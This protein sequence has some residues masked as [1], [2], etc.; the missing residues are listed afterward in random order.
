M[1]EG[2]VHARL[3]QSLKALT[4]FG[5]EGCPGNAGKVNK[6]ESQTV[7]D[8]DSLF[9]IVLKMVK[10]KLTPC[11]GQLKYGLSFSPSRRY[12]YTNVW[13]RPCKVLPNPRLTFC[14]CLDV[15]S[16]HHFADVVISFCPDVVAVFS[17]VI[18]IGIPVLGLGANLS[19]FLPAVSANL[20][21]LQDVV[22]DGTPSIVLGNPPFE[23][24]AG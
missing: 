1:L 22:R 16:L 21:T 10:T 5:A 24:N 8:H 13:Q 18:H 9:P 3:M 4:I 20:L 12:F 2:A 23:V 11:I 17:A 15:I 6:I 19:E 7:H 14:P